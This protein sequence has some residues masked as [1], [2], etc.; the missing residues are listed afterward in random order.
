MI[1]AVETVENTVG[2]EE[3]AGDQHF[4]RFS[5]VPLLYQK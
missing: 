4:L 5:Q 3:N 2:R 1:S